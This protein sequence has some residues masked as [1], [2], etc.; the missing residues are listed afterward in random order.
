MLRPGLPSRAL[1]SA[2][3][4]ACLLG[5]A[6]PVATAATDAG[7]AEPQPR[8]PN[9]RFREHE[10][11]LYPGACRSVAID[12]VESFDD[13]RDQ[14]GTRVASHSL[15]RSDGWFGVS[16]SLSLCGRSPGQSTIHL[17]NG[18]TVVDTLEVEV[19]DWDHLAFGAGQNFL[20]DRYPQV[21]VP[22]ALLQGSRALIYVA[23][24]SA[25]GRVFADPYVDVWDLEAPASVE[26]LTDLGPA[27]EVRSF[28]AGRVSFLLGDSPSGNPTPESIEL[29]IVRADEVVA[30]E[31]DALPLYDGG[32]S[33]SVTGLTADGNPVLGIGATLSVDGVAL[34]TADGR[35]LF[36]TDTA[37]PPTSRV[38]AE[39]NGLSAEL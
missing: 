19:A 33:Y 29:Q 12:G 23:P 4:V 36:R 10:R 32:A 2:A 6:E 13:L 22:I 35:W 25:D 26:V 14:G 34:P 5:C 20:S 27:M 31:L 38:V 21:A 8:N 11:F 7:Y 16:H 3:L 15:R 30:L 9:A 1:Q 18:Q 28:E 17:L 37:P 24:V 39:W